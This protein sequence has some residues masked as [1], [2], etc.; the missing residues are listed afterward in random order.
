MLT[1]EDITSTVEITV[2]SRVGMQGSLVD[3]RTDT[4]WESDGSDDH[5]SKYI[6]TKLPVGVSADI[7]SVSCCIDNTRDRECSVKKI[8]LVTG[9]A[10][11]ALLE[12]LATTDI[13]GSPG[14]YTVSAKRALLSEIVG[15]EVTA[16]SNRRVRVR[17]VCI[18]A[19]GSPSLE[20]YV[21]LPMF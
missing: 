20:K 5:K 12:P 10:E 19:S 1:T 17:Q 8:A 11:G 2:S 4:F 18:Y 9:S 6:Y 13:D 3:G 7:I 14:W 15:V 16:T 21:R